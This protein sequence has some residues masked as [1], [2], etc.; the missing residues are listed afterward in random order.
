[1]EREPEG[2]AVPGILGLPAGGKRKKKKG[3]GGGGVAGSYV[4][5]AK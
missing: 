3:R 1:M 5:R 4:H 2:P